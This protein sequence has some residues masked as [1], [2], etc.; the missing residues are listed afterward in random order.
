M[1]R[2]TDLKNM[3][4]K[5]WN[6]KKFTS[7]SE[8]VKV[9]PKV[10]SIPKLENLFRWF[11][12][13]Q[14]ELPWRKNRTPYRVW[15]SEIMLQQTR[16][17]TVIPYFQNW[18]LKFPNIQ[19]LA[20]ADLQEVLKVWEGLGYYRRAQLIHQTAKILQSDDNFPTTVSELVK[21]PGIGVYT[22]SAIAVFAYQNPQ[23]VIDGNVSRVLSR[24]FLLPLRFSNPKHQ[25]RLRESFQIVINQWSKELKLDQKR[26][27]KKKLKKLCDT[28][29]AVMELGATICIPR[30]PKC[31]ECPIS[32]KCC[33]FQ[34]NQISLFPP[35]T[36]Q[37]KIPT[38]QIAVGI[39]EKN[40]KILLG[41]RKTSDFLGGLW[42]LPGG[43]VNE[44]ET[45]ER[46]VVREFLEETGLK[47]EVVK[48]L[49]P[50]NHSF[51]H[52]KIVMHP[53]V[54]KKINGKLK[55]LSA[56]KLKFVDK[57]ELHQLPFPKA[58]KRVLLNNGYLAKLSGDN[59]VF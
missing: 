57:L 5:K 6:E 4:T 17:E 32:V 29:E 53:F 28:I 23:V 3:N 2:K 12:K 9:N 27:S 43:K 44:E 42:E 50:I 59:H 33:A 26:Q 18:M 54:V 49:S 52:F 10:E 7:P 8:E 39:L 22:A 41:L 51:T 16:V 46:A 20:K 40:Q 55:P 58:T 15:I 56:E 37:K 25:K 34:S 31:E 21:L 47:V 38:I 14:R 45:P 36:L 19:S 24:W 35:P 1:Y 13:N 30:N 48:K 11:Q